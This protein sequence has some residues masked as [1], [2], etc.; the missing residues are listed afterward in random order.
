MIYPAA[1]SADAAVQKACAELGVLT[2]G[3]YV[4]EDHLHPDAIMCSFLVNEGRAYDEL[5]AMLASGDW[6]PGIRSMDPVFT[7]DIT[8]TR[9]RNLP[10]GAQAR[11]DEIYREIA[12]G[13]L[14]LS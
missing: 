4:D 12:E 1:D 14:S 6:E 11:F 10:E 2:F 7:G 9:L 13:A 3:E 8:F 5:G